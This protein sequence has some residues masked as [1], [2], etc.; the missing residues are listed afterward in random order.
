[1]REPLYVIYD[2]YTDSYREDCVFSEPEWAQEAL[3]KLQGEHVGVIKMV[4]A[5]TIEELEGRVLL[6]SKLILHYY[7]V[8]GWEDGLGDILGG[9]HDGLRNDSR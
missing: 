6:L 7:G 5:S 9:T 1:M 8:Y 3:E 4:P 2:Y